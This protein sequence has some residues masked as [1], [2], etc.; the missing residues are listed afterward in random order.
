MSPT[1]DPIIFMGCVPLLSFFFFVQTDNSGGIVS[2]DGD[3]EDDDLLSSG[4][5]SPIG[6]R[7]SSVLPSY[8]FM[9]SYN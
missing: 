2:V 9:V 6:K 3:A 1:I 7:I 4:Q 5:V 8:S